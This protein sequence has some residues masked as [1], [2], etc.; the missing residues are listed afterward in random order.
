MNKVLRFKSMTI[1][2]NPEIQLRKIYALKL[3]KF[4][5]VYFKSL[6]ANIEFYYII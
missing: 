3:S 1:D 4:S 6:F 2:K 5:R